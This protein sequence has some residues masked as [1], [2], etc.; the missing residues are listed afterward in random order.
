MRKIIHIF[1]LLCCTCLLVQFTSCELLDFE[2]DS[3]LSQI[4]A[5]M[6]LGFD[7]VYVMRGDSVVVR[8]VFKPDSLNIRDIFITSSNPEV[9]SVNLLTGK[10]TAVGAGWSR[11]YVQS[12]SAQLTDSCDVCV[13]EVWKTSEKGFPYETIFYAN[14]T[15]NGKPLT[16]DMMVAA[17]VGDECRAVGE[18]LSF[19]GIDFLQFRVGGETLS[20]SSSVPPPPDDDEEDDDDDPPTVLR[21][22]IY[23]RLYDSKNHWLYYHLPGV[24]FDGETHG[25]PS[26]LYKIDFK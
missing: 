10:I 3:D 15:L 14:V 9:V 25:T 12:V 1:H 22:R 16:K 17:F 13:M 23:F 24:E 2:V 20:E 19:H 8:P 11:L 7:T 26:K 6:S 4:A 5:K 21:E 18:A